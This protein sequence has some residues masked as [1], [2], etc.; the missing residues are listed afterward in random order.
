VAT[1][2]SPKL[3]QA[4]R[5]QPRGQHRAALADEDLL[6]G[7]VAAR[8]TVQ[9]QSRRAQLPASP[10]LRSIPRY[11]AAIADRAA[12]S[13]LAATSYRSGPRGH[14]VRERM[15][16][17]IFQQFPGIPDIAQPLLGIF[18]RQCLNG[19]RTF[20]GARARSDMYAAARPKRARAAFHPSGRGGLGGHRSQRG[21][22]LRTCTW[23][24]SRRQPLSAD[25]PVRR[26]VRS[27][28]RTLAQSVPHRLDSRRPKR[29]VK[30]HCARQA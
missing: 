13:L 15:C 7:L 27:I 26:R 11:R 12:T 8:T 1:G 16:R 18:F 25:P 30:S 10:P 21:N 22:R 3:N 14:L 19:P 4:A 24:S 29:S 5:P 28:E 2:T 17:P 23:S 20:A 6:L 9:S